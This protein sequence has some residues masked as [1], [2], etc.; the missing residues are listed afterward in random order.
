LLISAAFAENF[1]LVG[2]HIS[3]GIYYKEFLE[4]FQTSA[5]MIS[6]ALS[7]QTIFISIGS[8]LVMSVGPRFCSTRVYVM[9]GGI[10]GSGAYMLN[11]F[12]PDASFLMLSQGVCFGMTHS[13]V[14]GPTIVTLGKYF[15][16]RRGLATTLSTV[17]ASVGGLVMPI[18]SDS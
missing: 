15:E 2:T 12:A 16:K 11:S 3:F 8:L 18:W 17:G 1:L 6:F 14:H 5:S 4:Y 10:T 7:V 9:I 13:F